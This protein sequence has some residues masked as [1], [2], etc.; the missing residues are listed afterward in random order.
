MYASRL[1]GKVKEEQC[2]DREQKVSS[3]GGKRNFRKSGIFLEGKQI[4]RERI[5]EEKIEKGV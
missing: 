2:L 3:S 4:E 1:E 5:I